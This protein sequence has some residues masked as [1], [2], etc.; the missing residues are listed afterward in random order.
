MLSDT[1]SSRALAPEN[2]IRSLPGIGKLC[3]TSIDHTYMLKRLHILIETPDLTMQILKRL[4]T[5][6]HCQVWDPSQDPL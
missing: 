6:L 1:S 4:W 5:A 3:Y 2:D